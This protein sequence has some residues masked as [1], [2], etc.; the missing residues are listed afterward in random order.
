[1]GDHNCTEVTVKLVGV[2]SQVE[3]DMYLEI[4]FRIGGLRVALKRTLQF[5][6]KT[7]KPQ[8]LGA[9]QRREREGT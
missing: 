8:E 7:E 3:G 6:W 1:M 4:R 2:C 5:F 9:V